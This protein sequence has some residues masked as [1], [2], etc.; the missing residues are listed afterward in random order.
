[1]A[2]SQRIDTTDYKDI[3]KLYTGR[4][5]NRDPARTDLHKIYGLDTE[6]RNGD[7]FLIADSDGCF[8]DKITLDSVI[9]FLFQKKFENSWN[10]FYNIDYDAGVILKLLEK[11][12]YSYKTTK[13]LRFEYDNYVLDYLPS[14]RLRISK[15]HHSRIFF[16]IWQF[17]HDSLP[18]A[19]QKNIGKIPQSYIDMK[20]KRDEFSAT[21]YRRNTN[22]VRQYCIDDCIYAKEL[23]Q[24]WIELFY[25]AFGFYL[26]RW[27]SSGYAAEK[28]LIN[29]G[30]NLPKFSSIPYAI[31]DL[32]YKSYFGGRFEMLKRGFVGTAHLYDINS[33]YPYSITTIPDLT[34]GKWVKRKSIH[35]KAKLGFF[36]IL[37]D[38]PDEKYIPP[39]PFRANNSII[40]PSG[41]FQ[42]F[43]T[44]PELQACN[45]SK[46]Y[47]ILDSYQFISNS[48]TTY[49][50]KKF[51]KKMYLK[52]LEL[53]QKKNPL[54]LPFKIILNSIYGKTGEYDKLS[55]R[56]GNLFNP[57]IFAHIT[58]HTRAQ[59]YRFVT[60]NG[61]D[62]DV[63]AFATDSICT[64]RKLEVG[65]E[66]LGQFSFEKSANN[67]LYLQNG[68]YR[69]DKWKQRG[70]GKLSGKNIEHLDTF[71][72]DG[73]LFIKYVE[74]KNTTLKMA[75]IQN[76]EKDIG[77]IKPKIKQIDLN[78][79]RKRQ[80]FGKLTGINDGSYNDS[81]PLSLNWISKEKI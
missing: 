64:T 78:A 49:P 73:G 55:K 4:I 7:L 68:F 62:R 12:L 10:F 44:L 32:A 56:I 3:R 31:Q 14:K 81:M 61:L 80:W 66:K 22:K 36:K 23:A 67:V 47:K 42:T 69:F 53:K 26:K 33:A 29:H 18:V 70:L 72:K 35:E 37:A 11:R 16:D 25:N 52:R 77:K 9:K 6:T 45:N 27:I 54:Q 50:Y 71:E 8:E 38:I 75:I 24:K 13:T 65:S 48:K 39:F 17:F 60:E 40:F 20:N 5:Q 43:V 58:G 79:D 51:I 57:V 59:L 2:E 41:K 15:G 19:Y 74:K 1:M 34:K 46:Y 28:V 21:Y 63:V 30:I 76:R